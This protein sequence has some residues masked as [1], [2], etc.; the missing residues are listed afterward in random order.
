MPSTTPA[1]GHLALPGAQGKVAFITRADIAKAAA[2]ALAEKATGNKIYEITGPKAYDLHEVAT[3]LA[4]K[5]NKPV[6]VAELPQ[7]AF[8]GMLSG[9]GLPPFLVEALQGIRAAV[10]AGEFAAVSNDFENSPATKTHRSKLAGKTTQADPRKI[11]AQ[12]KAPNRGPFYSCRS[13]GRTP[14]I[15]LRHVEANSA[16]CPPACSWRSTASSRG[17]LRRRLRSNGCRCCGGW[18]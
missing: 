18:L 3:L 16:P 15:T 7:E 5:W 9:M 2:A 14:V 12:R 13:P 1:G 17:A 11:T 6:A 10:G 8:A 4:A